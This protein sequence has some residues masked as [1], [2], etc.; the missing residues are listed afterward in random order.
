[1]RRIDKGIIELTNKPSIISYGTIA[2]KKE[3]EGPLGGEFDETS[4]DSLFGQN[5]F[6]KAESHLQKRALEIALKKANLKNTEIDIVF[7]GDLLN[8]CIGSSFGIRDFE[9]PFTGLYGACSTMALSIALAAISVDC[10][11]AN[12]TAAIT[13]SHFCS[14]E[15]Q[16][17]FPLEYGGQRT[18]TSQ[19]TVTGS[20][21]V[22][23]SN[24]EN[25][26]YISKIAI[27][28]INDL[29]VKD[30]NNMGAAMAPAAYDTIKRFFNATNTGPDDYDMIFTGDLGFVGSELLYKL[31]EK[32]N[33]NLR[34]HHK[35]CGLMIFDRDNQDVHCGGS[36]CGCSATVLCSHIL[37]KMNQ[38]NL[39]NILFCATGALLS[40][41]STMQ[42]ESI[43]CVAHLVQICKN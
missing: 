42:G 23:I 4:I 34:E 37:N 1:M 8:Q 22:I 7:A 11:M 27:G 24:G 10:G 15:R 33:I 41:T 35:D 25:K 9:I 18:P 30:A 16:Y 40:P 31:F 5:T 28:K 39:K 32:D 19:W 2:G 29:G 6:E 17:R 3:S 26:P 14:A 38:N 20:G 13:S 12:K 36:G 21:A 43:P